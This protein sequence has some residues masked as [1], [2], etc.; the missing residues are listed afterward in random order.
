MTCRPPSGVEDLWILEQMD[1][2]AIPLDVRVEVHTKAD[3][4]CLEYRRMLAEL[5]AS[6]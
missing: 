1:D 6:A 4:G 5:A 3:L 2:P